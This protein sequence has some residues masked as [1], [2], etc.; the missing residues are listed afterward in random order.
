MPA[1]VSKPQQVRVAP[2]VLPA[3]EPLTAVLALDV[4]GAASGALAVANWLAHQRDAAIRPITVTTGSVAAALTDASDAADVHLLVI[5]LPARNGRPPRDDVA[6]SMLRRSHKPVLAVC[7]SPRVPFRTALAAVDF[8]RSSLHATRAAAKL[9]APGGTLYLAHV[10]PHLE[11]AE[12]SL[13]VV[14]TQSIVAAFDRL[15]RE[16]DVPED[17]RIQPVI[18]QGNARHELTAFADRVNADL[19]ALGTSAADASRLTGGRLSA[20]LLRSAT[21][22]LLVAPADSNGRHS[23][24]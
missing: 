15:V 13:Q 23:D 16:L 19:I 5:G 24:E 12:G 2:V 8:T 4:G 10:Q 1:T 18:L 3:D 22:S 14:Y 20:S 7:A 11:R 9:L 17:V 21:R 6:L